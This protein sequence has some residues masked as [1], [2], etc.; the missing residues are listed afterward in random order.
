MYRPGTGTI[1]ILENNAGTF[2]PVYQG[3]GIGGYDLKSDADRILAFDYDGSGKS[4][5]LALYRPGTGI[6]WVVKN[7]AGDFAPIYQGEGIAG[8]NLI[9]QADQTIALD[10]D[11]SGKLDHP[12]LYRPGTSKISILQNNSGTFA[13]NYAAWEHTP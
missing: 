6:V 8:Y 1:W 2:T 11:G 3:S 7:E 13:P 12:L 4:D 10:Y 9:S 5:H